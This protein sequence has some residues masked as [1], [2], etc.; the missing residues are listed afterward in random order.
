MLY[1]RTGD[2]GTSGLF[3]TT[4]RLPKNDPLYEALGTLDELNALLGV[5]RSHIEKKTKPNLVD[6]TMRT[7]E[8]LFIIQAQLA[9]A[10][11][12]IEHIHILD[13]EKDINTLEEHL[14]HPHA[15]IIPG[16]NQQSALYD[17]ARAVARRMERR[18]IDIEKQHTL[19]HNTLIYI[20]RLSSFL[21]AGARFLA[22]VAKS[23]EYSPRYT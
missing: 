5:C 17:F 12:R 13:I 23:K 4:K 22:T 21:Y 11:K 15:F 20:N 14:T 16:A 2:N 8:C 6:M 10:D 18:I 19:P 3:G 7:Q 9:G 1:T